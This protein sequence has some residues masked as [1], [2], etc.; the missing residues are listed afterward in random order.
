MRFGIHP[1]VSWSTNP[2]NVWQVRSS[3]EK[4]TVEFR[5]ADVIW[6]LSVDPWVLDIL[7]RMGV[8][9]LCLTGILGKALVKSIDG[10]SHTWSCHPKRSSQYER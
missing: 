7:T 4:A 8:P 6:P 10:P 9:D 2:V 3:K 1:R 5:D